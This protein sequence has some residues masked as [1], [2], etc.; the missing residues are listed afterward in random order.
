MGPNFKLMAAVSEGGKWKLA[1]GTACS[2][3][4]PRCLDFY[5][6]LSSWVLTVFEPNQRSWFLF[7]R[8][9]LRKENWQDVLLNAEVTELHF[10]S[11]LAFKWHK[12]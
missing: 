10:S 11:I 8:F 3:N 5:N 7:I 2:Y 4:V 12:G 9:V 6:S 1:G